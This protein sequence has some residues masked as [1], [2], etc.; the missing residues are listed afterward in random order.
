[1]VFIQLLTQLLKPLEFPQCDSDKSVFVMLTLTFGRH[2]RVGL[3]AEG[4]NQRAELSVPPL[5]FREGGGLDL[6]F[7]HQWAM[8]SSLVPKE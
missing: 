5:T 8:I 3:V 1:M 4:T 7:S 6:G 2:L